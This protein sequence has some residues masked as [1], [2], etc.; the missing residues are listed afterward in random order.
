MIFKEEHIKDVYIIYPEPFVDERGSFTRK[1][2]VEEFKNQGL[3]YHVEQTNLSYNKNAYTL[4][5][6]HYQS[7]PFQ[8]AKTMTCIS[9]EIYD[10]IL[11]LRKDS[12][13]YCEWTSVVL[14]PENGI[15]IHVPKG[16][17]NAFLTI[18]NDTLVHYYSSQKYEPNHERGVNYMDPKF[19]FIW[20]NDPLIVSDKDKGHPLFE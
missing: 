9:G 11:D 13:T 18:K 12:P 2:C 15:S 5:G 6:F 4:R 14:N 19:K 8:E 7:E 3:D 1:F 20:P 16:C 17:A 10:I